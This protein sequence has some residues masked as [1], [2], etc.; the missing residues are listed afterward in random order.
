MFVGQIGLFDYMPISL[1]PLNKKKDE[2]KRKRMI[3]KSS[4]ISLKG[5]GRKTDF[6]FTTKQNL[7]EFVASVNHLQKNQK[8]SLIVKFKNDN[9]ESDSISFS[10]EP[11]VLRILVRLEGRFE[12]LNQETHIVRGFVNLEVFHTV[13]L[14]LLSIAI[15]VL[16]LGFAPNDLG[17]FVFV[18]VTY[19]L[20][21]SF[22]VFVNF[23]YGEDLVKYL[24][25]T[26]A[27]AIQ[28]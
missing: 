10:I 25:E 6:E 28:K 13:V 9:T 8:H 18:I 19:V 7:S 27:N 4:F 23:K 17:A 12:T 15:F 20:L 5:I 21:M 11:R 14:I 24:L 1:Y 3:S 16:A 26:L 22:V 2:W